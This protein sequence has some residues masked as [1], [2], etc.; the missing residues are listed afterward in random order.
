M[1]RSTMAGY[2][3]RMFVECEGGPHVALLSDMLRWN[4]RGGNGGLQH[5]KNE[6][7]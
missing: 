7:A 3:K 2:R 1:A 5:T 4:Q 6:L